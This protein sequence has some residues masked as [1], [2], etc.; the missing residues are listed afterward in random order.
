ME[1]CS[2][3]GQYRE[4]HFLLYKKKYLGRTLVVFIIAVTNAHATDN[5]LT[6]ADMI[7]AIMIAPVTAGGCHYFLRRRSFV[8][9][10]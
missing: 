10:V 8:F 3:S 2:L 5:I 7:V 4:L 9:A 1:G 6:I